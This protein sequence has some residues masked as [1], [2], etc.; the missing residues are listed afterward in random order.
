MSDKK[1][2]WSFWT[3]RHGY[4]VNIFDVIYLAL[5]V[6][7]V[8][9][10]SQDVTVYT[11]ERGLAELKA[12]GLEANLKTLNFQINDED[13]EPKFAIAKMLAMAEQKEQFCHIDHDVF[14]FKEQRDIDAEMIVQS[15]EPQEFFGKLYKD[16]VDDA[17]A[18]SVK[19]P[20]E[21]SMA[22]KN[23]D[24][25]ACNCGYLFVKDLDL[26]NK[27]ISGGIKIA[28][29]FK[30]K[31]ALYNILFEQQWLYALKEYGGHKVE[32]L[33]EFKLDEYGNSTILEQTEQAG[34]THLM[35]VKNN[36]NPDNIFLFKILKKLYQVN[37]A[38]CLNIF[39]K[40]KHLNRHINVKDFELENISESSSSI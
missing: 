9:K 10:F 7:L 17:L 12:I 21:L 24:Y 14:L 11:D 1:Y 30:L 28:E 39:N 19:F 3:N 29:Q 27:W 23:Y 2:I 25:N 40:Y 32:P 34:Y 5:S 35:A 6:E 20:K 33:F 31:R 4:L 13:S 38:L 26:M 18:Q 36:M 37:S 15:F 8:K 22:I 16:A